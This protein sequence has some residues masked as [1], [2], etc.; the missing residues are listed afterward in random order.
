MAILSKYGLTA[1]D[2]CSL[3]EQ[4][5]I[6]EIDAIRIGGIK[7]GLESGLDLA[8]HYLNA[9]RILWPEDK[10]HRWFRLGMLGIVENK[11][12][13]M[14]GC[15]NAS[16][17]YLMSAHAL[18]DFWCFPDTSLSLISSTDIRSL[19]LRIWGRGIKW[20]FNRA[21]ARFP[22]LPG[23]ILESKMAIVP[24]DVDQDGQF[25]R[26]IN[27]GLVCVP[28][29]SG[30][31]F[32]GMS[33]FQG[34]KPPSS[35]GK[36][37]GILKHYGDEVAVMQP[38]ILDG[39]TNWMSNTNFK[40]VMAGN[41]TDISDPLCVA[42]EPPGGWD[43]FVDNCK[44]QTW[45]SRWHDA[46]C[47][48]FDGRDT[49]NN[50]EPKD[51]YS[52][53]AASDYV[54]RLTKTYGEDSWQLYQQG[55]G[56][57]SKGMVSNRVIT[58]GLCERHKAFDHAVWIGKPRTKIYALDPAYGGGDRCVGGEGEFGEDKDGNIILSIGEPE[59][60][61]IRINAALEPEE[62]ISIF[63]KEKTERLG[64]PVENIFYDAFGRGT[65]GFA[66][67]KVFG[68]SCPNPV[69]S[70][71]QPTDRPVRFDLYVEEEGRP[72]RLKRC[73]EHYSKFVTEM[74]FSTR[75]AIESNQVRSLP[76]NVAQEGQLRMFSI[77]KGNRIE[78]ESKDVMKE[79]IKKSPDLYDWFSILTEGAR[80]LGFKIER[81]GR[82]IKPPS[83]VEEDYFDKQAKEWDAAIHAGLL[84]H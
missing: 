6:L 20:L 62:Q 9:H 54:A 30:G 74:W 75:E 61:P 70:G 42:S 35:P 72:R 16:K 49:P 78:V 15:A 84:K 39:Y 79:R 63:I 50:D 17:T 64:I 31:R 81:I 59:I 71:A 48:A 51:S 11:V 37:D 47:I 56:K 23:Y 45:R 26:E 8:E 43:S 22:N 12:T 34:V 67:A 44:T 4:E 18:I 33:K 1:P 55:I 77:V 7:G 82:D 46:F 60:I 32:V 36:N 83:G 41:P 38:S 57:P 52:F 10:Q 14:L 27:K 24:D 68:A 5:L 80:R 73:N 76:M 53:L 3:S 29:V 13:I 69:D 19:E 21:R 2:G 25:A 65:L 28:C 66:F 40:G 58:I